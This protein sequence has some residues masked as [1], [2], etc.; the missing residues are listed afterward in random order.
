[1]DQRIHLCTTDDGVRIAYAKSGRGPPLVKTANW[2]T[3]LEYH[4][5]SPVWRHWLTELSRDHMLIRYDQRGCGL[6]DWD[7]PEISLEAWVRD[8][9]TV[10]DAAGLDRFPLL[11]I[12]Q[13]A[14]VAVAFAARHPDRVTRLVLHGGFA[15]GRLLRD[16]SSRTR[17]EAEMLKQLISMGW[18]K[19]NPA[20]RQ[21]FTTLF[22]PEATAEQMAWVRDL[23]TVVDAAGLDRF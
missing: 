12:C 16:P 8:L 23:E 19:E 18:G 11:G 3:H 1:M 2:L 21:V 10:V 22:L 5:N 14:P 4:W 6:S 15:R 17:R 20:F 9:E 13:G 7:V